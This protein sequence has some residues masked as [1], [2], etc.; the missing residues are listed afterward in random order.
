MA[1]NPYDAVPY[2]PYVHPTTDPD[3]LFAIGRLF[4]VPTGDP[5]T[6]RVLEIGCAMGTNIGAIAVARPA[7]TCLGIDLSEVQI[8][9]GREMI[10][11]IG[12]TNLE[13]RRASVTEVDASWGE[14]DAILCHGVFSWVPEEVRDAIL[15]VC[16]SNLAPNG[17]A[18]ISYNALPGWYPKLMI[19]DL[20][21]F[22]AGD[23]PSE[24]R[25]IEL[26]R[27]AVAQLALSITEK[28]GAWRAIVLTLCDQVAKAED[29]YLLHEYLAPDNRPMYFGEFSNRAYDAGLRYV[30]DA[31]LEDQVLDESAASMSRGDLAAAEQYADFFTNRVFR[32]SILVRDDLPFDPKARWNV[33]EQLRV[34]GFVRAVGTVDLRPD[35]EA[36]FFGADGHTVHTD[37]PLL[38]AA[39]ALLEQVQPQSVP[40]ET[41]LTTVQEVLER[42]ED[43]DRLDLRRQIFQC[44]AGGLL[45]VR[46]GEDPFATE[47]ADRPVASP[48]A[49]YEASAGGRASSLRHQNIPVG[50]IGR[51]LIRLLDG[52]HDR[53][54]LARALLAASEDGRIGPLVVM[55]DP[56][57]STPTG[58]DAAMRI[59]ADQL[60]MFLSGG[61]LV[62]VAPAQ[63]AVRLNPRGEPAE[64]SASAPA[65]KPAKA[66]KPTKRK[67]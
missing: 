35:V 17:I 2:V 67:K 29:S 24:R 52:E 50:P 10:D 32:R 8:A 18:C 12:V 11:A 16:R 61:L 44:V 38:K 3:R 22:H 40:F 39:L 14:F 46:V 60:D 56:D 45:E 36:T 62:D 28:D 6:A 64:A 20:M 33:I 5:G 34:G 31:D 25:R 43:G 19:R 54:A 53:I 48:L 4:G 21:L 7:T 37:N 47:I 41:L 63:R 57:G 58:L 26:A 51:F 1:N 66:P 55:P 9:A 59:V 30:A 15:R 23:E 27:E 49:R 13:L 65:E 42:V